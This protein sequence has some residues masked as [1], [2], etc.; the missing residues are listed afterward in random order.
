MCP[1]SQA[2]AMVSRTSPT[3]D[4]I[5]VLIK[6]G[7]AQAWTEIDQGKHRP[8]RLKILKLIQELIKL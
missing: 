7:Q 6:E 4:L 1:V 3:E 2:K 8:Y 5:E